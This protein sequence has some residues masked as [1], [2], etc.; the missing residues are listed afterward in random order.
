MLTKLIQI[1]SGVK[2][3]E[4]DSILQLTTVTL[5][6]IILIISTVIRLVGLKTENYINLY[7]DSDQA[8]SRFFSASYWK[9]RDEYYQIRD[10][11]RYKN[12]GPILLRNGMYRLLFFNMLGILKLVVDIPYVIVNDDVLNWFNKANDDGKKLDLPTYW[13]FIFSVAQ[14]IGLIGLC[15]KLFHMRRVQSEH[16]VQYRSW[17]EDELDCMPELHLLDSNL[18]IAFSLCCLVITMFLEYFYIERSEDPDDFFKTTYVAGNN[19]LSTGVLVKDILVAINLSTVL[20]EEIRK[21]RDREGSLLQNCEK[22][23]IG[24]RPRP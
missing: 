15:W 23:V 9:N 19:V 3:C 1:D 10:N 16:E 20:I 4:D 12:S 21:I 6:L 22:I 8:L 13:F 11:N 18:D 14:L 7:T 24:L 2:K 5:T 17:P